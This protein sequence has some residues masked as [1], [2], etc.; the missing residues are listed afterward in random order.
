M[1]TQRTMTMNKTRILLCVFA[2]LLAVVA[3]LLLLRP[4]EIA[5][6]DDMYNVSSV[7]ELSNNS[8]SVSLSYSFSE[9]GTY[10]AITKDTTIDATSTDGIYVRQQ[11]DGGITL[12]VS[13]D[14]GGGGGPVLSYSPYITYTANGTTQ[15][16]S[17]WNSII[18][19]TRDKIG[20]DTNVTFAGY[21]RSWSFD[22]AA[23]RL[24]ISDSRTMRYDVRIVFASTLKFAD[25]TNMSGDVGA[26]K[27]KLVATF[28]HGAA[29]YR[30]NGGSSMPYTSGQALTAAGKYEITN[31]LSTG[32]TKKIIGYMD[33]LPPTLNAASEAGATNKAT[34]SVGS[35][36]S[37]VFGSY[38]F[39]DNSGTSAATP[40]APGS[41]LTL[42]GKYVITATDLAGNSSSATLYVD[43]TAP[44]LTRSFEYGNTDGSV[45]F[46]R[47]EWESEATATYSY[48]GASGTKS[49]ISYAS[50][51]K[52]KDDGEYTITAKDAAGNS[53]SVK[54][55]V[56]RKAPTL[57]FGDGTTGA[58]QIT[59]SNSSVSW[60]TE[61]YESPITCKYSFLSANEA[62][63]PSITN[64]PYSS[65]STFT[66]EGA[67][68]FTATD[69]ASNVS[70]ATVIIDKTPP[71]LTFS[72]NGG[73]FEKYTNKP[74]TA[75]GNDALSGLESIELYENGKYVPYDYIPRSDNCAYLFRITD[76]A[77]NYTVATATV[78]KTD[79]FGNVQA[80]RDGYK[81]NAWYIVTLPA[82]IFT[83]PSSDVAG[84]YSFESYEAALEFAMA[85]EREFRVMSVQG[86]YMY[87]SAA[88]ESVAQKYDDEN[89][90]NATIEKYA[91]GYISARQ[92]SSSSGNDKYYTE[93]E[94]LT[95]NS[96]ILPDHLLDLKDLPRYF[97]R[98]SFAWSLPKAVTYISSMPYTVTTKYLGDFEVE[99]AQREFLIASNCT[100]KDLD[101]YKQGW[102]L[103]TERDA[104]GNKEVY[105]VYSDAELP[106]VRAT[107]TTGDGTN[108]LTLDYDYTRNNTLYFISLELKSLLDNADPFVTLKLEKGGNV[109]YFTQADEL[110]ALGSDEYAS[111][112]YTVTVLDRSLNALVFDVY[113]AG[114]PPAMTHGS[115]AA[116][117]PECKISFVTSDRYN[118]IT[119]ITLYKIEY[120]GTKTKLDTDGAG[121]L[122]TAAT[123]GYTLTVGGKYGATVTDNYGRVVELPQIFFLKGLPSGKL[124]GVSDGGRTNKNVSFTFDSGDVC[125]LFV[126]LPNGER[127]PFTDYTVQ[128]G[129]Y[130][131]T[132]NITADELTSHEYL[133]FLH[134]ADDLSLFVEYTFEIDTVLPEFEITDNAGRKIEPDGATNKPFSIKWSETGVSVRYYTARGG[135]MS[136]TKYG[137]NTVL[138]Q[139]ALYYFTVKDDV[140]NVLEFTVLL[141]NAVDYTLSGNYNIVD[142]VLYA[143]NP[144]MFTV[145]EPTQVFEI[146]NTDG[147]SINNGGTLTQAGR[148]DI[149]VTDNYGNTVKLEI[150][151]DFTP[152]ILTLEGAEANG[153]TKSA[154]TV[155]ASDYD[156]LYLADAKGNKLRDV[157]DGEVFTASGRYYITASDHA[158]NTATVAFSIDLSVDYTLSVPSGAVTPGT[159]TLDT[160]EQLA[161]EVTF[162]GELIEPATKFTAVGFYELKLTDETGN[163]V[164]CVFEI[165]PARVRMLEQSMPVGTHIT[166]VMLDGAPIELSDANMLAFD[167]TGVYVVTLDC[168]GTAFEL[169]VE[170][171]NTP[172]VVTLERDGGNV[173]IV[174]VDK[175]NI[176]LK[177]TK[178]GTALNCN[179]GKTFDDHGHYILTVTDEL[180]NVAVYEFDIPFRLNT[181]AIVAIC[182]GGVIL[183]V[184]LV[185]IIRA[186]RKP[187]MK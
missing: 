57:V 83:T 74:F 132:Y 7:T 60:K 163:T 148:Y 181:W 180:G 126:L 145:N 127:R 17:S 100:L 121:T 51:A 70:H 131:T 21:T 118:V 33:N 99:T 170:V 155:Y 112:K 1:R 182:V 48:T 26:E 110:P 151:L 44:I 6:A 138:S 34:W 165:I 42:E 89:M 111:G 161:V 97:A 56:D 18:K 105:L 49:N 160:A 154:V 39:T 32:A 146:E 159:V 66:A 67:Y 47:A 71:T 140:G 134:N 102:Y 5:H 64:A 173:K 184:V 179:V 27:S 144:L 62:Q 58:A 37:P 65:G 152:P 59:R 23:Q 137:M 86:G 14:S 142:G 106:A 76:K 78:Y 124:S 91:K 150:A 109:S 147:Y 73:A 25:G 167:T 183:V 15:T 92:T 87:V 30:H 185:L 141:D 103:I 143:N 113:I 90:L 135:A 20:G 2:A 38:V 35:N 79:T 172:P 133:V 120:D 81:I 169:V 13:Y 31:T 98:P 177:L 3:A 174:A 4:N 28:T 101:E 156:C 93:P 168:G 80:I 186:R 171:D 61:K 95:R 164:S 130:L 46:S 125:E 29:E 11:L 45:T 69:G 52:L 136:A 82:R 84:R 149:T 54:L 96:P 128:T 176:E 8:Q 129:A 72:A 85:K 107:A 117:K 116:D 16:L 122:I 53:S 115:L 153:A 24:H 36:E 68:T 9:N 75:S 139:G 19:L 77:G 40:Y 162:N 158:G 166:A 10:T 50:G 178:D 114:A 88:N 22:S 157:K 12:R 108:D 41:T 43:K 63:A 104:A 55:I 123:L 175:D 187:R 94:S 119:S